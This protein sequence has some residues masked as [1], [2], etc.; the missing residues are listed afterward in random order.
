MSAAARAKSQKMAPLP[1]SD[2][3][4]G[5]PVWFFRFFVGYAVIMLV[6]LGLLY[7]DFF[8]HLWAP[9]PQSG[10]V[11]YRLFLGLVLV[12]AAIVVSLLVLRRTKHN[13]TGL[14]LLIYV[15]LVMHSTLRIDSP[16]VVLNNLFYNAW[17]GFWLLPLYFPDGTAYP[18]RF[19][20]WVR[21]YSVVTSI[22][23]FGVIFFQPDTELY[24]SIG[25]VQ[26]AS[27]PLR[28][29]YNDGLTDVVTTLQAVTWITS[30]LM[31]IPSLIMRYRGS[32]GLVR[33]QIKLFVWA[34]TLLIAIFLPL[35]PFFS[36]INRSDTITSPALRLFDFTYSY[37]LIPAAPFVVVGYAILRH[38]LY[39][40]DLIIRRTLVYSVLTAILVSVYF[41]VV[42]LLQTTF[43]RLIG[44]ESALAVVISTLAI[45][46][47]F[48]PV[49]G[50]VQRLID[51]AF[52][53]QKY[54]AEHTLETFS[55][56][57]RDEVD[58]DRITED[59]VNVVD[60]TIRPR[61][62]TIWLSSPRPTTEAPPQEKE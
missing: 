60:Q 30:V 11:A 52:Y 50:R 23:F 22:L 55:A 10:A 14:F 54:D 57:M 44:G 59:L 31:I 34:Y 56:R 48:T 29:F 8:S 51:R 19:Q 28:L 36:E 47:L 13:V 49:R 43:S 4:P 7:V 53:R 20:R 21:I 16:L 46:G 61:H 62:V 26:L 18:R 6:L 1:D 40:I 3:Q 32:K 41:G 15:V 24:T 9:D 12:P 45:A 33:Q 27:N 17:I 42:T 25:V 38:R 37:I 5:S 35:L 39:D 58:L 2:Q